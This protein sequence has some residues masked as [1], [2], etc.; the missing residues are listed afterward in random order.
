MPALR[1]ADRLILASKR[2][3]IFSLTSFLTTGS[4]QYAPNSLSLPSSNSV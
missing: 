4:Y 2:P 3:K 1:A